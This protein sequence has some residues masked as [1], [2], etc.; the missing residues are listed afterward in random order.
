MLFLILQI[1]EEILLNYQL[2]LTF[3]H[4]DFSGLCFLFGESC[5]CQKMNIVAIPK[6]K[7]LN[8]DKIPQS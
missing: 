8:T 6:S 3:R 4:M 2:E 7:T 1:R 5:P